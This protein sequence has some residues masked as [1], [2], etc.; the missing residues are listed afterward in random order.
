MAT[1][2]VLQSERSDSDLSSQGSNHSGLE[3]ITDDS[4]SDEGRSR[5]DNLVLESRVIKILLSC[6]TIE[7][8]KSLKAVTRVH[9]LSAICSTAVGDG[10]FEV[11]DDKATELLSKYPM[12]G[13]L[14]DNAWIAG[15]GFMSIR[16]LSQSTVYRH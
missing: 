2:T 8:G 3:F 4:I 16:R 6:G 1:P 12:L 13:D 11:D 15:E 14:V 7:H 10:M 5:L 9:V